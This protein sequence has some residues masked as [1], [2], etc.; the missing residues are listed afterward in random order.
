MG[1]EHFQRFLRRA[2]LNKPISIFCQTFEKVFLHFLL[3]DSH[4]SLQLAHMLGYRILSGS[5]YFKDF[6]Y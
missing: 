3:E 5:V 2:C 6:C 1:S 4:D